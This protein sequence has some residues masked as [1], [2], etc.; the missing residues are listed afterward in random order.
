M[1]EVKPNI[2]IDDVYKLDVRIGTIIKVEDVPRSKRMVKLVVDFGDFQR[3]ILCGFKTER[4]DPTEVEGK[5]AA[6]IVNLP[7]KKISGVISEGMIFD[8]GYE[9]G[10]KPVLAI[11][12]FKVPNGSR[13]G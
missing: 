5:Q 9:D 12:E 6:F 8:I 13:F 3:D 2:S 7:P 4:E 10:I 1:A 11:P